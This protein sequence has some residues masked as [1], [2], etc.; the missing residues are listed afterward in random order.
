MTNRVQVTLENRK[1]RE[2]FGPIYLNTTTRSEA[3]R[4][5][6]ELFDDELSVSMRCFGPCHTR[7]S[8]TSMKDGAR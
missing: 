1:V 8:C 2:V 3:K 7:I 4:L 5:A 6:L